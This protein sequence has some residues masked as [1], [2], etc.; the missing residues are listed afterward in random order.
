MSFWGRDQSVTSLNTAEAGVTSLI[1][2]EPKESK[3][4]D[5]PKDRSSWSS[6][7]CCT[8]PS[9]DSN[10]LAR[11]TSAT[12]SK[13]PATVRDSSTFL[14]HLRTETRLQKSRTDSKG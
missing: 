2:S 10:R 14:L 8:R 11:F 7:A 1:S 5:C 4:E 13:A 9:R 6:E 12:E 3:R